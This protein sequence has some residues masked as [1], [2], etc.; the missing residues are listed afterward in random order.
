[1]TLVRSAVSNVLITGITSCESRGVE[2]LARAIA[3]QLNGEGG[4]RITVLTQTPALDEEALAPTGARCVADPFVISRSWQQMRPQESPA[5]LAARSDQ[6]LTETDLVI[7]TGGDLH[8]SD[9]GVSTPY[10]RGLTAAQQRDIPTAMIGQSV[11]PF[12]DP[13]DAKAWLTVAARCHLLTVRESV[14]HGYLVGKLGLPGDR[15]QLS[16]DPAF[17]LPAATDERI[18]AVLRPLGLTPEDPY[19]CL[20][21]SQGITRFSAVDEAQH[22]A[23]LT[24]LA[25]ALVRTREMPVV[26]LPHCHDSRPHN[27]DRILAARIAEASDV[28]QVMTLP[29]MLSASDYKG[30]LSRAELVISERLHAAIGALSSGVPAITIG[31]SHKFNGVLAE[32]Y[33]DTIDVDDIHADVRAFAQDN[34]VLARLVHDTDVT[35]LR[36]TLQQRLP[37]ITD[38]ARSDFAQINMLLGA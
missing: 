18:S 10:L 27:D 5:E 19:V 11:G 23:A 36:T 9:Y 16:S 38:R 35:V 14:S 25:T 7:A 31:H 8:T 4:N 32:T 24:R 2:A 30:V 20:A 26:L 12:D 28:P 37:L 3:E 21:S 17:L 29:G 22:T 6:L 13:A 15:V 33:G 34:T 1:M